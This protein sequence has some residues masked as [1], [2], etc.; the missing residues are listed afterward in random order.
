[1]KFE[2]E[3]LDSDL[4]DRRKI[5]EMRREI[6]RRIG[7]LS[8]FGTNTLVSSLERL[9]QELEYVEDKWVLTQRTRVGNKLSEVL[10]LDRPDM[11]DLQFQRTLRDD[12]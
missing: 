5:I 3:I 1:M 7:E 4:E 10:N 6:V 11:S 2:F 9:M 12:E 8:E